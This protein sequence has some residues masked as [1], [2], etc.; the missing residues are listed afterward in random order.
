M[1]RPF[2]DYS[3]KLWVSKHFSKSLDEIKSISK[4]LDNYKESNNPKYRIYSAHDTNVA[5]ILSVITPNFKYD[6]VPFSA[7]FVFEVYSQ[8]KEKVVRTTYNGKEMILD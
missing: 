7:H 1:L 5:N 4:N 2:D 3:R 6:V 8:G